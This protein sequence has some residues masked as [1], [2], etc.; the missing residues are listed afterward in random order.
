MV[1]AADPPDA[2]LEREVWIDSVHALE[3]MSG[4]FCWWWYLRVIFGLRVD[5]VEE[6]EDV[7]YLERVGGRLIG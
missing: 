4:S 7:E 2:T 6:E 1:D 5:E 3:V